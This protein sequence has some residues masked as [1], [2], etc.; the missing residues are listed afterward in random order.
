MNI[1]FDTV[2]SAMVHYGVQINQDKYSKVRIYSNLLLGWNR[3]ISLTAITNPEEIL[4]FH[5]GE[6]L[7][8]LQLLDIRNGRLADVGSGA[9]FPALAIKIFRSDLSVV[10]LEPNRKKCA[11]LAEVIRSLELSDVEIASSRFD[12]CRL[13]PGSLDFVTS[14]ALRLSDRLLGWA[15]EVLKP[16]GSVILW[17]SSE[18]SHRIGMT[19]GW[20]WKKSQIIPGTTRREVLAGEKI[21]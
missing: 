8:A 18:D 15:H 1:S 16:H 2:R 3:K 9:G 20:N 11:F 6:S 5:F 17:V 19:P 4:R 12:D 10:L 14:R 7:F 21:G 13:D